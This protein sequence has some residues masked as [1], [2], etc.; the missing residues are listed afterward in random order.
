ML[1][2]QYLEDFAEYYNI[3]DLLF[4]LKPKCIYYLFK[5]LSFG[6]PGWLSLLSVG[7]LISAQVMISGS[8][9]QAL[10]WAPCSV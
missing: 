5:N 6:V 8:W 9:D 3:K 4:D 2:I 1:F 10:H 7:L